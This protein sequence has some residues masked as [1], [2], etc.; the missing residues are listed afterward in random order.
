MGQGITSPLPALKNLNF[1]FWGTFAFSVSARRYG[2]VAGM[3]RREATDPHGW[4][5]RSE[6]KKKKWSLRGTTGWRKKMKK[7]RF[8]FSSMS[9]M[10][11]A[12]EPMGERGWKVWKRRWSGESRREIMMRRFVRAKRRNFQGCC[13]PKCMLFCFSV[14]EIVARSTESCRYWV[15]SDPSFFKQGRVCGA[16]A[17]P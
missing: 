13:D 12:N 8:G 5:W 4:G 3:V 9:L 1:R 10:R 14:Q 17:T 7:M 6:K 2:G 15:A 11:S 16:S